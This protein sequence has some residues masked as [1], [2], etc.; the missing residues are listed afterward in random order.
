MPSPAL[1]FGVQSYCFRHFKD[2]ADV[3]E[4]VKAIGV[5]SIEVC[6]IHADFE[7]PDEF[8]E[9]V[10]TY[11]DAD[12]AI[13]SIGVQTFVGG[14]NERNWFECAAAAGADLITAHFQV[15]SFH[16]AVPKTAKLAADYGIRVGIHCHGGYMFGGSRDIIDH[17][18][19]LGDGHVGVCIDT[20]WC[21]QT[22]PYAGQPVE[23]A[24]H[25][26]DAVFGVH[27]KDFVFDR[28]ARWHDVVV[29]TGTLDLPAFVKA[30]DDNGFNGTAVLE[31]EADV[32]NPVPALTKCVEE[33]R[34]LTS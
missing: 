26:A 11:R 2:N 27:Y 32:E 8:K 5:N 24:K 9:V 14:D 29:G 10:K 34:K 6:G 22:G 33:M 16:T 15:D 20:A 1:D 7:K 12:V 19:K 3:A 25:Y 17:L 31:Y 28:D 18:I 30:L 23:W 13:N 4:K 21:M